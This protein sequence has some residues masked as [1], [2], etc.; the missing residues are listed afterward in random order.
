M[1]QVGKALKAILFFYKTRVDKNLS[2][3]PLCV[4]RSDIALTLSSS[5]S[6]PFTLSPLS[7]PPSL[8]LSHSLRDLTKSLL[9]N[10]TRETF[11]GQ[12]EEYIFSDV[13]RLERFQQ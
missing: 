3:L 5:I 1:E 8:S 4:M 9:S 12:L 2:A 6:L 10:E 11:L 7:L 13:N